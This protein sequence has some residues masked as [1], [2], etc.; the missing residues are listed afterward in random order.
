MTYVLIAVAVIVVAVGVVFT[1]K[2]NS[3][4]QKNGIETDAV[5]SR[6]DEHE[7]RNNDGSR[8][9]HYTYYVRYQTQDGQTVEAKLGNASPLIGVGSRLRIKYLPEKPKYVIPV[10]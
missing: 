1:I 7:T 6:I 5:V 10:K 9:T 8:E 4:I 3:A 2:R